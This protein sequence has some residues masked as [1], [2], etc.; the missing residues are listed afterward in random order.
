M[1]ESFAAP[2][3]W[4]AAPDV[5]IVNA[6]QWYVWRVGYPVQ[7]G[8][9]MEKVGA[10]YRDQL[11]ATLFENEAECS[12][13]SRRCFISTVACPRPDGAGAG[14]Y[15]PDGEYGRAAT[16]GNQW[17]ECSA[18]SMTMS[19]FART[20]VG[21]YPG[22]TAEYSA[23]AYEII[24]AQ[25]IVTALPEEFY[26][27]H[28]APKA[29]LWNLFV[30]LNTL[31]AAESILGP[32]SYIPDGYDLSTALVFKADR[33][34]SSCSAAGCD[35]KQCGDYPAIALYECEYQVSSSLGD[36]GKDGMRLSPI[37][38]AGV[39]A[40]PAEEPCVPRCT[41]P[42]I[43]AEGGAFAGDAY[44]LPE[45]AGCQHQTPSE[46]EARTILK[47]SWLQVGGGGSNP[48]PHAAAAAARQLTPS[49][50]P[51]PQPNPTPSRCAA[52]RTCSCTS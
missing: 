45:S 15:G 14:E 6:G 25:N 3:G 32:C 23:G 18:D 48:R 35:A 38:A 37:V 43:A 33:S 11:N 24:D 40:A 44:Q 1:Q 17:K 21:E 19:D 29:T 28:W 39:G 5:T 22:Y 47:G 13:P 42:L 12:K 51:H 36:L 50:Q 20:I 4:D 10:Q 27:T 30:V 41:T 16:V 31:P 49:A 2:N 9:G 7:Y 8:G 46:A 52:D 34:K 26:Q